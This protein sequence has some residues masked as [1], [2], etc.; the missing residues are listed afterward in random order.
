MNEDRDYF[1]LICALMILLGLVLI[2]LG[3]SGL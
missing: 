2:A 3:R 1:Y